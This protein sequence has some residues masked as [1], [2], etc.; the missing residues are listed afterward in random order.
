MRAEELKQSIIDRI[1]EL[2]LD[3]GGT[4]IVNHRLSGGG[5]KQY[6][7]DLEH[8]LFRCGQFIAYNRILKGLS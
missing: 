6:Q 7:K 8:D 1:N 3:L 5:T 2:Q 4:R